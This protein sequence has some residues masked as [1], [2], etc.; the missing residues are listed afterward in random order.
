MSSNVTV[1]WN[2][3]LLKNNLNQIREKNK[4]RKVVQVA[5]DNVLKH[6]IILIKWKFSQ[7]CTRKLKSKL[8]VTID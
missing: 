4:N 1:T 3:V 8:T 2:F 6:T 5:C 7:Q